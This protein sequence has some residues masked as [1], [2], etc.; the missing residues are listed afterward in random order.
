MTNYVAAWTNESTDTWDLVI[1]EEGHFSGDQSAH[2]VAEFQSS[3]PVT[4]DPPAVEFVTDRGWNVVPGT[5][6]E[7]SPNAYYRSVTPAGVIECRTCGR[8]SDDTEEA[9]P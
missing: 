5:R 7:E 9:Q 6:W 2:V 1:A 4:D 3:V 8:R